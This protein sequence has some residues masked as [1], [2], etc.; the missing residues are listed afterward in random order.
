[1]GVLIWKW[2]ENSQEVLRNFLGRCLRVWRATTIIHPFLSVSRVSKKSC[3][4]NTTLTSA[5]TISSKFRPKDG[6]FTE[7]L[8]PWDHI[9]MYMITITVVKTMKNSKH[10]KCRQTDWL[11]VAYSIYIKGLL[12]FMAL[13]WLRSN[14]K[15]LFSSIS[16]AEWFVKMVCVGNDGSLKWWRSRDAVCSKPGW[17]A[18]RTLS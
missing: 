10:W 6:H 5:Y 7:L 4:W 1:M 2:R 18:A 14:P 3:Y 16:R 11:Y 15:E 17:T 12:H 8:G 13:Q 9:W